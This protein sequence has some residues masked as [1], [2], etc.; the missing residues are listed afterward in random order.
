MV[1]LPRRSTEKRTLTSL[2]LLLGVLIVGRPAHAAQ[3]P[4]IT[5]ALPPGLDRQ[6]EIFFGNDFFGRGGEVDDYRTQQFGVVVAVAE[7]WNVVVDHSILTLEEPQQGDPGRL[8][9]LSGSVGYRLAHRK[10]RNTEQAIE[11]G[12]G[13]RYSSEIGGARIQNGFHQLIDAGIKTM[14]YVDTDRIDGTFWLRL[15]RDGVF[16]RDG[17]VPLLGGG[18]NFGYWARGAT[19]VTSDGQ[20][21]G[22]LGLAAVASK[23]WFQAWLGVQGDWRTG[24][25]RDN[26]T[27]ETAA[28]E[29]G[30][31]VV[32]GLRFGPL[33]I[34]TEQQFD[35][36]SAYGHMSLVSTG[37]ALA[38]FGK[39]DNHF[40]FQA[41]LSMPD[42]YA[43]LQGRWSNCSLLRCSPDWRRTLVLDFRYG[44]PQFGN[45]VDKFVATWQLAAALEFEHAPFAAHDWLTAFGS[46]G[47]GWRAERIEGEGDELGGQRSETVGRPG[48]VGDLGL[49]FSTS[50]GN[51]SWS[52]LLQMGVSGWL[53]SSDGT[54]DFADQAERLQRPEIVMVSGILFRFH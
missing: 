44:M 32:I 3:I 52:L 50:A 49:R 28:Y 13:F 30:A 33:L 41:G 19:L 23:R 4:G 6:V 35:G 24:Y 8:D 40:G 38:A 34:E 1:T 22:N 51:R 46:A 31:A 5:P 54:V 29:D 21:D 10:G 36:D 43:S 47:A 11:V 16:T 53:P 9:Q 25:D 48:L 39:G 26:V 7:R 12:G 27:R 14:P 20:W 18:W 17:N 45:E 42:V 2:A 37:E 15:D